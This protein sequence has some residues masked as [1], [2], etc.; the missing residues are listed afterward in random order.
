MSVL[1]KIA[2]TPVT[3]KVM[4]E[5]V[6]LR[7]VSVEKKIELAKMLDAMD[8]EGERP[9]AET[10]GD[11]RKFAT[12]ILQAAVASEDL[13]EAEWDDILT[14]ADKFPD[15]YEGLEELVSSAMK[16]CGFQGTVIR[17]DSEIVTDNT[18]QVDEAIGDLPTS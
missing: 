4:G 5:N 13:S 10:V 2:K 14:R 9:L 1:K 18:E 16:V 15:E 17:P 12:A 7:H 11:N 3:V 6:S 8:T